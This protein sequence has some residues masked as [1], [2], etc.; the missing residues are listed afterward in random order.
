MF[1]VNNKNISIV[2]VFDF[3]QVKVGWGTCWYSVLYKN[4]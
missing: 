3:E 2:S 4:K 1:R